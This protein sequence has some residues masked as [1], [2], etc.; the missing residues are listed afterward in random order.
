MSYDTL[1]QAG[2]VDD[3]D[4]RIRASIVDI[5]CLSGT[6]SCANANAADGADYVGELHAT[7]AITVTD[8][9]SEGESATTVGI[10]LGATMSCLATPSTAT[11]GS[12]SS[13]PQSMR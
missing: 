12:C 9:L 1:F 7:T 8:P 10:P 4:V 11:G 6:T 5:R 13:T 2:G 3:T